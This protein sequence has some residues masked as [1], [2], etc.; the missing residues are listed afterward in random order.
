MIWSPVCAANNVFAAKI[1]IIPIILG[2]RGIDMGLI[3]REDYEYTILFE[4]LDLRASVDWMKQVKYIAL[5]FHSRRK[6]IVQTT[7]KIK[8]TSWNFFFSRRA[9]K[10]EENISTPT[11]S[12]THACV[13][14]LLAFDFENMTFKF[15]YGFRIPLKEQTV[16]IWCQ[17]LFGPKYQCA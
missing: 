17:A 4:C 12:C 6:K 15:F 3:V 1:S 13:V 16:L 2:S 5:T 8:H 9:R 11:F 10:N 7:L 14:S